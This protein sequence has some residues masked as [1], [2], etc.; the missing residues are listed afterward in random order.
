ML[1]GQ[2]LFAQERTISGT[3]NDDAGLPLPGVNIII[4][5]TTTGTQ[6]DFDGN[7]SIRANEGQTLVFSYVGFE[8]QSVRVGTSN[9]VNVIM[10]A[11]T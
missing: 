7:Y 8:T 1:I 3:V 5:G 2:L 11:G 9:T 4:E 6:S 10:A